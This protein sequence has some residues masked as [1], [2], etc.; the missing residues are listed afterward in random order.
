MARGDK[1]TSFN[2]AKTTPYVRRDYGDVSWNPLRHVSE[3]MKLR[4]GRGR[5]YLVYCKP[6]SPRMQFHARVRKVCP[7]C[8]GRHFLNDCAT[9]RRDLK[10]GEEW[11]IYRRAARAP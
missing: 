2:M 8:E 6:V 7:F 4:E 11:F 9:M 3:A 1:Q 5:D 10:F